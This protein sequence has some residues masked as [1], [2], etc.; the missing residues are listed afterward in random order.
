MYPIRLAGNNSIFGA[1]AGDNFKTGFGNIIIGKGAGPTA[2]NSDINYKLYID[3]VASI[4]GEEPGNDEP[5]IYGEFDNDFVKINDT[6]EMTAGLSKPSDVNLKNNFQVIDQNEI[7]QKLSDLP[8]KQWTYKNR[9]EEPHIGATAQDFHQAF[10]LGSGDK[11]ISTI[12][13]DG[14]ALA[15]IQALKKQNDEQQKIIDDLLQRIMKLENRD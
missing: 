3:F 4:N 2:E 6:F 5:L 13:A 7:L 8:I 10:G 12:N 1:F 14:V 15:A 11:H 9:T